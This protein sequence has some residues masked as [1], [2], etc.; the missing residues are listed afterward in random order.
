MKPLTMEEWINSGYAPT[1]T[2]IEAAQA[3]YR[4]HSVKEISRTDAGAE[5]F[6]ETTDVIS[7]II[8]ECKEKKKKAICFVTGVPGA[9]KTLAGL[10]I[11]NERHNLRLMSMLFSCQEMA[12]WSMFSRK[13]SQEI[14]LLVMALQRM[15]PGEKQRPSS[16]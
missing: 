8:D 10:N 9:G 11:A 3:L 2:I 6:S 12:H 13:H 7:R 5:N 4:N 14:K 15:K 1:L 16:K